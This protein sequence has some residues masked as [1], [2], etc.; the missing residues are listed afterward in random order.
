MRHDHGAI[1]LSEA[2]WDDIIVGAGSAGS[3]L[4]SRLSEDPHR[5]VLLIEAGPDFEL[6]AHLPEALTDS[7]APAISGFHWDFAA[8]LGTRAFAAGAP[9]PYSVGKVVGG[10]SAINGAIALRG[11]KEDFD[12]WAAEGLLAWRWSDVLPYFNRIESDQDFSGPLHGSRGPLP[13]HRASLDELHPIQAAFL[14]TCRSHG[15]SMV[16]DLNGSSQAGVGLLPRNSV[17]HRRISTACAYLAAAR[18]R[19]NLVI[20]AGST[21]HRV[22]FERQRAVGVELQI[23]SGLPA[24]I[25]GQ[26]I[27]LCSG[28][29]N[30]P[31]LLQRSGIGCAKRGLSLGLRTVVDLP[32]VGENLADH[33]SVMLWLLP[34]GAAGLGAGLSHHQTMARIASGADGDLPDLSLALLSDY[35]TRALPLGRL[36]GV[37]R[38]HGLSVVLSRPRSRGRVFVP[39]VAPGSLPVIELN[40]GAHPDDIERLVHGVR[41]AWALL[42]SRDMAAAIS[43]AFMWGDAVVRDDALLR[44]EIRRRLAPTW[45]PVGT[46]RMGPA[47]DPMSVVDEHGRVHGAESLRVVDASIMPSIPSG[48]PNLSCIMLAERMAEWMACEE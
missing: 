8:H 26:R 6:P 20:Q 14:S 34:E 38:V 25:R 9:V 37:P 19:P 7:R 2:P 48:P 1:S 17:G 24:M 36:L 29:L 44:R 45:H 21:V 4:A 46:A 5:R 22:R 11:F 42:K 32:G 40:F 10:S 13:I 47:A 39:D 16:P 43:S 28:A 31:A 3:V 18:E 41:Q 33:P 30:T 35:P 15:L 27:T 23:G 12:R